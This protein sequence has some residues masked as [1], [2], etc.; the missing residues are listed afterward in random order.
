[1]ESTILDFAGDALRIMRLKLALKSLTKRRMKKMTRVDPISDALINIKNNERATK[2]ECVIRPA[3]KLLGEILKVM[4]ENG[5]IGTYEFVD[6]GRDGLYKASLLGKINEC[7]AIKPRYSVKRNEFEKY[8]KRYL[9]SRDI[10]MLVVTTP[11]GVMTHASAKKE[12][13]G[14]KLLAYIY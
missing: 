4:Q 2:K 14:G 8:E 9:P 13:V 1:M 3:S 6:D 7:K 12:M 11:K 5:Y 10:G